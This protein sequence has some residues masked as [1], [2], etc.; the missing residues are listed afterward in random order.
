MNSSWLLTKLSVVTKT[1][2]GI[3]KV[4]RSQSGRAQAPDKTLPLDVSGRPVP[5]TDRRKTVAC[6]VINTGILKI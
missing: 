2:L 4:C 1:L 6:Y 5:Q 3:E